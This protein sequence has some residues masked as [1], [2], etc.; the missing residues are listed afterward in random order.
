MKTLLRNGLAVSGMLF[1][2]A[3]SAQITLYEHEGFDGQSLTTWEEVRSLRR[4]AFDDR[5]SSVMVF[6][7]RWEVCDDAGFRGR[8][9]VLRP[10]RYASLAAM[11]LNNRISSVRN[12]SPDERVENYRYAP[13][14]VVGYEYGRRH[15]ERLYEAQVTSVHAVVGPREQRCWIEREQ[16]APERRG[17]NV[18]GALA[19]AVIGGILGHQ[20]GRGSGKDIATAGGAVAGAAIGANVGRDGGQPGYTQ[21]VQRCVEVP[22]QV[23]PN[24]WDVTYYFQGVEHH[25]QMANPPGPNVTVNKFGEPRE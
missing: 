8:C 23:R 15:D 12:L 3:A 4:E 19:G 10:G 22:G 21:D 20:V 18:P 1:A 24:Y 11:G 16:V 7:E 9:V 5:A 25:A 13:A 6:R 14:P 2:A 17:A